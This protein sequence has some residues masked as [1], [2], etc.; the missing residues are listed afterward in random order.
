[1]AA[2]LLLPT[3]RA[4]D[5]A[6]SPYSGAQWFFYEKGTLTPQAV[7]ADP[8][9]NTSLGATVTADSAGKF[10][11]IYF[12]TSLQYRGICKN[13]TGSVTLHDIPQINSGLY[14]LSLGGTLNQVINYVTPEQ[15]GA[16]ATVDSTTA[17]S[18]AWLAAIDNG[19][20]L[21]INGT[22]KINTAL[23][24]SGNVTI[25]G[26]GTLDLSDCV[27]DTD[28]IVEWAVKVGDGVT[29]LPAL[30]ADI[31]VFA[32]TV[33]FAS[34]HG[35][36][37]GDVFAVY[38]PT[39]YSQGLHRAYYRQGAMFRVAG[40]VDST[41]VTI[42]G[43][44]RELFD[45]DDVQVYKLGGG[46]FR[47][48]GVKIIPPASGSPLLLDGLVDVQLDGLR[49]D[50]GTNDRAIEVWRCYNIGVR[51]PDLTVLTGE[52]Y[53]VL[54]S[55]S[56]VFAVTASRGLYS[57]WHC[58]AL[59]GNDADACVPT[60]DGTIIGMAGRNI[61]SNGVA[62]ADIHGGCQR[63]AYIG[64]AAGM[65][66][67]AGEDV[68]L[69]NCELTGRPAANFSDGCSIFG[70]EVVGGKLRLQGCWTVSNGTSDNFGNMLHLDFSQ[71][72]KDVHLII[73][74]HDH[75]NV[76][77]DPSVTTMI[78]IGVGSSAPTG[79]KINVE[80][81]GLKY[82]GAT[83]PAQVLLV[84][85]SNDVSAVM[86]V[87]MRNLR[88]VET[89]YVATA[90]G[91]YEI[92]FEGP[93]IRRGVT[94]CGDASVTL[95]RVSTEYQEFTADLTAN[96]TVTLPVA[97]TPAAG[98]SFVIVRKGGGAFTLTAGTSDVAQNEYVRL[99]FK[100][101]SSL[102]SWTEVERGMLA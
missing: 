21:V 86:S 75:E 29:A 76:A 28:G 85:G 58:L 6:N 78:E 82:I 69:I 10:V 55:N 37:E 73:R 84:R 20:P 17:F 95:T 7:Y 102:G 64:C 93:G 63:I 2:E 34:A 72:S 11:P 8:E 62:A 26:T 98:D 101:L 65:G 35:L 44:A 91:N 79:K 97:T 38:N 53:P 81:D 23:A 52:A 4:S 77:A 49:S 83:P 46:F 59:G 74:D 24:L 56:Q 1:M 80:I 42:F 88:G 87:R 43:V 70:S 18:N 39:D 19:W 57:R 3:A 96:R 36:A 47:A 51:D 67:L 71:I 5:T 48:S 12:D 27:T 99:A 45:K 100:G 89:L 33:Q 61:A 68:S 25:Q 32:T 9:L 13:A 41:H 15:K 50:A 94:Q 30:A 14:A 22:V 60:A 16:S 92:D 90:A 40:V 66:T 31:G 54:I